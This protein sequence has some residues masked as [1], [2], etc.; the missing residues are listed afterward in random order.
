M[1]LVQGNPLLRNFERDQRYG[2]FLRKM[3]LPE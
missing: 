2:E 3:R 1:G